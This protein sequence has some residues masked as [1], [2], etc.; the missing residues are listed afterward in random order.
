MNGGSR[1]QT[2]RAFQCLHLL[3]TLC[4]RSTSDVEE[5]LKVK[6]LPNEHG[7]EIGAWL[8]C[9]SAKHDKTNLFS[10]ALLWISIH[11]SRCMRAALILTHLQ[12]SLIKQ[13]DDDWWWVAF[14]GSEIQQMNINWPLIVTE[15]IRRTYFDSVRLMV[16]QYAF[17]TNFNSA[18]EIHSPNFR[19]RF[20]CCF[21]HLYSREF[22]HRIS[23]NETNNKTKPYVSCNF[24]VRFGLE[25]KT[26]WDVSLMWGNAD[27]DREHKR[28]SI[29]ENNKI[30]N[31][32]LEKVIK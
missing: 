10:R 20:P 26:N 31:E 2:G 28:C 8:L 14:R 7:S 3:C 12:P 6:I 5:S 13:R 19:S 22:N 1:Q 29:E 27:C 17:R 30:T 4:K 25:K 32:Y 24:M 23:T 18:H 16:F 11:L 9:R 15:C 21:R